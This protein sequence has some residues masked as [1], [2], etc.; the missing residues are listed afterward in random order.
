MSSVCECRKCAIERGG[1]FEERSM[2]RVCPL[3]GD[4]RCPKAEDHSNK[5]TPMTTKLRVNWQKQCEAETAAKLWYEL[6]AAR[7][8]KEVERLK[9]E[10]E[11]LRRMLKAR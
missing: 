1:I 11:E 9:E 2:M 3:C 10:N 7:V 6:E 5:C 8:K 4:K